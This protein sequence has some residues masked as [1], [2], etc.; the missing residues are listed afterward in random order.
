MMRKDAGNTYGL[1][2]RKL[3]AMLSH[4]GTAWFIDELAETTN[5]IVHRTH[6]IRR[7]K[8]PPPTYDSAMHINDD[9]TD[10]NGI[11]FDNVPVNDI[12][13]HQEGLDLLSQENDENV[14]TTLSNTLFRKS[15]EASQF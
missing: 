13:T 8:T 10:S 12:V 14:I 4:D 3:V 15:Q 6:G 7:P 1:V 5:G 2:P 9:T 11:D